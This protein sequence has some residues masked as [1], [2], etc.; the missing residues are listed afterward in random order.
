MYCKPLYHSG[1]FAEAVDHVDRGGAFF[2]EAV[3]GVRNDR[4]DA[5]LY[6]SFRKRAVPDRN[7]RNVGDQVPFS[8]FQPAE[9]QTV[10][11]SDS[12]H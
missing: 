8:F 1:A 7:A 5:G 2:P 10:F 6:F 3:P 9:A 11:V 12:H 4:G